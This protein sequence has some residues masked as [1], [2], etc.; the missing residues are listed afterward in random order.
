MESDSKLILKVNE[1]NLYKRL[2]KFLRNN[3][4]NVPLSEIYKFLR[5]GKVRVNQKRIR[6]PS[7]ELHKGDCV[8]LN[9][10]VGVYKRKT[11]EIRSIPM[12]L[13][14]VFENN[15]FLVLNKRAGVPIHPAGRVRRSTLIHGLLFYGRQKG[16]EPRLVHRLDSGTSGAL[17]VA[18]NLKATRILSRFF[19][20]KVIKKEYLV[21]VKGKTKR[22]GRIELPLDGQ[23]ALTEFETL[24]N[25]N[26]VTLLRV[27]IHTGRTHQIRKHL[28]AVGFP[29]VG[30]NIYGDK[31]FNRHFR[32]RYDLRRQ[33]LHCY[34]LE[35][36]DLSQPQKIRIKVPLP[37]EL[38][39]ILKELKL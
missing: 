12:K 3:L 16:F 4:K 26:T 8:E 34:S 31:E 14:I 33:F 7:Y 19:K 24:Q 25:Y 18:K 35:F 36:P 2:D 17:L 13:E 15:D 21:L 11:R 20:E 38:N 32:R 5:Q 37:K 9:V 23:E 6:F 10:D 28:A 27:R 39:T 30:D 22:V 1:E 29:V